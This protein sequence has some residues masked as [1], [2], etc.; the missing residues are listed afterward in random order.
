MQLVHSV[1]EGGFGRVYKAT[2]SSNLSEAQQTIAVKFFLREKDC[3]QY[4]MAISG[5]FLRELYALAAIQN[6]QIKKDVLEKTKQPF[7]KLYCG[8]VAKEGN[9]ALLMEYIDGESL[10]TLVKRLRAQQE[11]LAEKLIWNYFIQMATAL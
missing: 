2:V 8:L 5:S 10:Y 6:R 3:Q 1:G 11:R 9:G 4:P 7:T